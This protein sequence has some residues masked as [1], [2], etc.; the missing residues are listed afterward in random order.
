[1]LATMTQKRR[2]L[3]PGFLVLVIALLLFMVGMYRGWRS[4]QEGIATQEKNSHWK[5]AR[6]LRERGKHDDAIVEYQLALQTLSHNSDLRHELAYEYQVVGNDAGAASQLREI[7]SLDTQ[8]DGDDFD[9][10][11]HVDLGRILERQGDTRQALKEYCLASEAAPDVY[12][13]YSESN[14]LLKTLNLSP[15]Y[16]EKF[17]RNRSA[18]DEASPF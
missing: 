14:R 10:D 17:A 7:I 6:K 5:A 12:F 13:Y 8:P 15:S 1:M 16:C 4:H 2:R 18:D 9:A 3:G 11:V